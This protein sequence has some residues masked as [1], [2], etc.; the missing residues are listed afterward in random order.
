[1][2]D[3][4]QK[5]A[6]RCVTVFVDPYPDCIEL[7]SPP[8]RHSCALAAGRS[9]E[10]QRGY[11]TFSFRKTDAMGWWSPNAVKEAESKSRNLLHGDVNQH[12]HGWEFSKKYWTKMNGLA[13]NIFNVDVEVDTGPSP[14]KLTI[15]DIFFKIQDMNLACQDDQHHCDVATMGNYLYVLLE[16][17]T[18]PGE[19]SVKRWWAQYHL[20]T[21]CL[22]NQQRK[23]KCWWSLWEN[24]GNGV[25]LVIAC[26]R[27]FG[28]L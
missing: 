12:G 14:R 11:S 15:W 16:F 28:C 7:I 5:H 23:G 21:S 22:M 17:L 6:G 10:T 1:M 24:A 4:A 9:Q 18:A 2:V 19:K 8:G 26:L 25:I 27:C 3:L 20:Q 13:F